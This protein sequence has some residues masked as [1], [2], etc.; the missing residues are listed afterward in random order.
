MKALR[1][2]KQYSP[3]ALKVMRRNLLKAFGTYGA[4]AGGAVIPLA[5]LSAYR[6]RKAAEKAGG[7]GVKVAQ[8]RRLLEEA[9]PHLQESDF[10]RNVAKR[11][12]VEDYLQ[13]SS[14]AVLADRS[15]SRRR[16]KLFQLRQE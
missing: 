2:T 10:V 5:L 16:P 8:V 6:Q 12:G 13:G 15:A 11:L 3:E 7:P 4:A 14:P 1:A 9:K